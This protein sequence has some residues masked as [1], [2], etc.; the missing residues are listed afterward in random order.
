[1]ITFKILWNDYVYE[2]WSLSKTSQW[3]F[4]GGLASLAFLGE[5]RNAGVRRE[6]P[7]AIG[8]QLWKPGLMQPRGSTERLQKKTQKRA[9]K[10]DS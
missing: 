9:N 3:N 7:R 4:E 1:M 8:L 10:N 6:N 5:N 2:R